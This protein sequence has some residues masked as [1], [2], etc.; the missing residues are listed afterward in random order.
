MLNTT[1]LSSA[2]NHYYDC[3]RCV[4]ITSIYVC[5]LAVFQIVLAALSRVVHTGHCN[6]EGSSE[7]QYR[8]GLFRGSLATVALFS[9]LYLAEN[10]S[11]RAFA[12]KYF[13][14]LSNKVTEYR[15]RIASLDVA[16]ACTFVTAVFLFTP[17][18]LLELYVTI[19]VPV[20]GALWLVYQGYALIS[21]TT[22]WHNIITNT[23]LSTMMNHTHNMRLYLLNNATMTSAT[24]S[25]LI[26]RARWLTIT[27]SVLYSG[28]FIL[29]LSIWNSGLL[30]S[31]FSRCLI[32][33]TLIVGIAAAYVSLKSIVNQ[34]LLI[35][36]S[37]L[38]YLTALCLQMLFL[39]PNN[40]H[41]TQYVLSVRPP[42]EMA[43]DSTAVY[44]SYSALLQGYM[45]ANDAI[46]FGISALT[47]YHSAVHGMECTTSAAYKLFSRMSSTVPK[48]CAL[49]MCR[50]NLYRYEKI[51]HPE[52]PTTST[53]TEIVQ[54]PERLSLR[55]SGSGSHSMSGIDN[56]SSRSEYLDAM[57]TDASE[58]IL[59]Q[60]EQAEESDRLI[61]LENGTRN[62]LGSVHRSI[63]S[64]NNLT[65]GNNS[66]TE[67]TAT[68][69]ADLASFY[70]RMI[71]LVSYTPMWFTRWGSGD[72]VEI[73]A[74][75][76]FR[77]FPKV[78]TLFGAGESSVYD[79]I[80][81]QYALMVV[82][83]CAYLMVC[84]LYAYSVYCRY[85]VNAK[86]LAARRLL[87]QQGIFVDDSTDEEDAG[88]LD[89]ESHG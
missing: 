62:T 65:G 24:D 5:G 29:L 71:L 21:L 54:G 16:L 33:G 85:E 42:T 68:S 27:Y 28:S 13:R 38:L 15:K 76:D 80:A 88:D 2:F 58:D 77:I 59:P 46:L 69:R 63:T 20:L 37:L 55:R 89:I 26:W 50:S 61:A 72:S 11:V 31:T 7:C 87:F 81:S 84:C 79:R 74:E 12:V 64:T 10:A 47:M 48:L 30:D 9:W 53:S 51:E 67:E 75:S 82:L 23:V 45:Y 8:N 49:C 57:I 36:T 25:M 70:L 6:I 14:W 40:P 41:N 83:L 86:Y 32:L 73:T 44:T 17:S 19:F 52:V 1:F 60:E 43:G 39:D 66:A 3:S 18:Y 34:G 78:S 22:R 4:K 35:P 56:S